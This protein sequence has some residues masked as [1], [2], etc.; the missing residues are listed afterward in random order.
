MTKSVYDKTKWP[1]Q[2]T[3]LFWALS[4]NLQDVGS[5]QS[6][7]DNFADYEIDGH[8]SEGNILN[9]INA[10]RNIT[11]RMS[12]FS[13][14]LRK[15]MRS[16]SLCLGSQTLQCV[17]KHDEKDI[18]FSMFSGEH[19]LPLFIL[20]DEK[21]TVRVEFEYLDSNRKSLMP[22]KCL[23]ADGLLVRIKT[24]RKE[25]FVGACSQSILT[26]NGSECVI[27]TAARYSP[28]VESDT[29]LQSPFGPPQITKKKSKED[30]IDFDSIENFSDLWNVLHVNNEEDFKW[31][32]S[33]SSDE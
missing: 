17:E 19:L 23:E 32:E 4:D 24:M 14:V 25:F 21:L 30:T 8:S 16:A 9:H 10:L 28:S 33:S 20:K 31:E 11:L 7:D 6:C 5:L 18:V 29:N 13:P 1:L 26:W 2:T 3:D 22:Y 27:Q 15:I 12:S